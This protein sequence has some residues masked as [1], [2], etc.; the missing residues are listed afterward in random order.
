M[1]IKITSYVHSTNA[2]TVMRT[3]LLNPIPTG[4]CHVTLIYGLILPM[5]GRNRVK[6]KKNDLVSD[7]ERILLQPYREQ[8]VK[9]TKRYSI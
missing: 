9:M 8:I 1:G 7:S 4:C 3:S 2:R 5:A 6:I